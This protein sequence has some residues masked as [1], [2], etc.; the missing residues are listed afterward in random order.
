MT[1]AAGLFKQVAYKVEATFG[2]QPA[3][4]GAQSLRRVTSSLDLTKDT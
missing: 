2:A 1:L 4:S 3:A